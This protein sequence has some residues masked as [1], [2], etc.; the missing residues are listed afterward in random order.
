M[1][2]TKIE[3]INICKVKNERTILKNVNL[4]IIGGKRYIFFGPSGSGKTTLLRLINR[5]DDPTSGEILIDGHNITE[6]PI[7][8]LRK[9]IGLVFQIPVIFNG[10]VKDNLMAPY[11]IGA[12]NSPPN[13]AELKHVLKLSGLNN[14][15]LIRKASELSIG[16]KQR[17]NIARMLLNKPDVLLLDEPT[18]ALD[19]SSATRLL[20]SI[21]ELSKVNGLTIIMVTH[22]LE[23]ARL[24]G[25]QII[26]IQ[27]GAIIN[28]QL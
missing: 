24:L 26:D 4:K 2:I 22:Q 28:E 14:N 16:E 10:T 1:K 18:S 21:M 3:L 5:M 15:F 8:N 7:L 19:N 9:K 11:D 27:D 20:E 25:G 17:V 13:D 23:Y 6:L 12:I